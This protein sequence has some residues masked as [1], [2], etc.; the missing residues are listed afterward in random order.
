M[1]RAKAEEELSPL[2]DNDKE[3]EG[4]GI[5]SSPFGS[6]AQLE[7]HSFELPNCIGSVSRERLP[8]SLLFISFFSLVMCC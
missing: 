3:Q 6:R 4:M 8:E 5:Q 1:A 2:G 7:S